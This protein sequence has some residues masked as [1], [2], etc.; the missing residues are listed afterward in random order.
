M[1]RKT[2]G[3]VQLEWACPRCETRNP[4][5]QKFCNGC[6]GPQPPDVKFEQPAQEKLLTDA[7]DRKGGRAR[8]P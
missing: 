4:G 8:H 6:G 1:T 7:G 5:P 3:Y 2:V